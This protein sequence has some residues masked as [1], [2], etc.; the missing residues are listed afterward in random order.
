MKPSLSV[1]LT[2]RDNATMLKQQ[3]DRLMDIVPEFTPNFEVIIVID[4]SNDQ[5]SEIA[6]QYSLQF[7][8]IKTKVN[9]QKQGVLAS[10]RIGCDIASSGSVYVQEPEG[11]VNAAEIKKFFSEGLKNN[12]LST[13]VSNSVEQET[14]ILNRL[15][16]W[17]DALRQVHDDRTK[18]FEQ[19]VDSMLRVDRERSNE[20]K[21]LPEIVV[22]GS[23]EKAAS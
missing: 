23:S 8:Q 10:I 14:A 13:G 15:S 11:E 6:Q 18:K 1:V 4:G 22:V 7:P 20:K 2:A 21:A 16:Q 17:C 12:L 5:T 19:R 3:V 9:D